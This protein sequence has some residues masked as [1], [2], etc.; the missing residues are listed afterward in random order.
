MTSFTVSASLCLTHPHTERE[1]CL[2]TDSSVMWLFWCYTDQPTWGGEERGGVRMYIYSATIWKL[3]R[4]YHGHTY[5]ILYYTTLHYRIY[6]SILLRELVIR[7]ATYLPTYLLSVSMVWYDMV[8]GKWTLSTFQ[9]CFSN[10]YL[11]NI[12]FCSFQTSFLY[13]L[14]I[15]SYKPQ[16]TRAACY[17]KVR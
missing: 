15:H 5:T 13:Y 7:C 6:L 17:L 12:T 3:D 10:D 8:G 1:Q 4:R 9:G 16:P 2:R 14:T 11:I